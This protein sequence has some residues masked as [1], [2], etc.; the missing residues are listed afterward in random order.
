MYGLGLDAVRKS[1]EKEHIDKTVAG[2]DTYAIAV[3]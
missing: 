1:P 3:F 2:Q